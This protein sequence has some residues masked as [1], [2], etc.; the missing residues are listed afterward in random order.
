[1][2]GLDTLVD[3]HTDATGYA[4]RVLD[5]RA[6]AFH[7]TA[8]PWTRTHTSFRRMKEGVMNGSWYP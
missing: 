4:P 1:M 2:R 5:K 8:L 6:R 7:A 3:T